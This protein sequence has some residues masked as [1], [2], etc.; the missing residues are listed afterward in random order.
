M[1][2]T[3]YV[4]RDQLPLYGLPAAALATVPTPTQDA[5]CEEVSRE[6]DGRVSGRYGI[7]SLPFATWDTIITGIAGRLAA[8]RIATVKGFNPAAVGG[9]SLL[10]TNHKAAIVD[11]EKIQKQQLHPIVT[12]NVESARAIPQPVVISSSVV[13]VNSGRKSNNRGW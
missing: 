10:D 4:T 2:G 7:G 5:I 9:D 3:A 6:I 13:N 1:P 12:L 8:Y 11:C